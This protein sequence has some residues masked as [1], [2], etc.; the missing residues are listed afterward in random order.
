MD[1]L[2]I[3]GGIPLQGEIR[4]SGAKNAALP[5][6]VSTLLADE[7]VTICN[8]PHLHDITTTMELLG[9]M[10]VQITINEKMSVE[11]DSRTIRELV[12]PYELVKTMRASI[13]VLGPLLAR[14]GQAEVSLP[15]GCAIG[16]RPVNLHIRGLEAMGAEISVENGYIKARCKRL[17]GAKLVMDLVTVTGTENLMMAA[18]LADGITIIENAA[19]EP[20]VVDLAN[21][22]NSMGAKISGAGSD[23]IKIEGV[24]RLGG[25]HYKVL[26]DR[27]ET[28]TFLVAAAITGGKIK[29]KDTAPDLLDAVLAKLQE[30][31]ADIETGPDWISL[32]MH[33]KRPKSVDICTAPYPAFPTD[34]QAQFTVLNALATGSSAITETVFE[35]RF[36]HVQELQRMGANIS[37][38]GNTAFATGV[39]ELNGAPVMATDLRASASLVIAGL[40]ASGETAVERIY[41]IDRGY[42]CIEEKLQLL[43]AEIRRVPS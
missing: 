26:P 23:T 39:E 5:I 11:V 25:T 21:C 16:S 9:R 32:D 27:I 31:G 29:L 35:N 22:L 10:G 40:I 1:K 38:K 42:E 24:E 19:R 33:G 30:A 4:I 17:K 41:H 8:V 3:H 13:L 15:G 28:G 14:H 18:T 34:M 12:A 6:I 43:G 20:E 2:L 7:P 36:M 37:L